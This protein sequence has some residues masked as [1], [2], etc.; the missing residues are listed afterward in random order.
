MGHSTVRKLLL[1][2]AALAALAA[3]S[4]AAPD[5]TDEVRHFVEAFLRANNDLALSELGQM[6]A[7]GSSTTLVRGGT[8]IY[9]YDAIQAAARRSLEGMA[10]RDSFEV[11]AEDV[12]VTMLGA[13]NA[14]V[15]TPMTL[16]LPG[17]NGPAERRGGT[18]TLVLEKRGPKWVILHD[19]T[20]VNCKP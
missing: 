2:L 4:W 12:K 13:Q 17:G 5:P 14:Y 6:W 3:T 18:I 15:V 16:L 9:G 7:P 20:A 10:V 19:H 11:S 8:I 1:S